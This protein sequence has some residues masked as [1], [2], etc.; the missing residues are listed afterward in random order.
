MGKDVM[1]IRKRI[2]VC[3]HSMLCFVFVFALAFIWMI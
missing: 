3:S 2:L 1:M